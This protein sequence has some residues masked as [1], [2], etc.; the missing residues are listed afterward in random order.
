VI[1]T[2]LA[3]SAGLVQPNTGTYYT[4]DDIAK[5]AGTT[6]PGSSLTATVYLLSPNTGIAFSAL[7][8]STV[9]GVLVQTP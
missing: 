7:T 1:T 3:N 4:A 2:N 8:Q 6:L 5:L 9:F